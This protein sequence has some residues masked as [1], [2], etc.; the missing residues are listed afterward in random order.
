MVAGLING[1]FSLITF[2]NKVIREVGCGLYLLGSSMTTLITTIMFSLKFLILLLTQMTIISNRSFLLFQCHLTDFVLR[3]CLCMDQWLNACVA[4]ERA[5]TTT[6]GA[7]F[8]KKKS[9]K[10]SEV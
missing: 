7:R 5:I 9:K 1:L 10:S 6:K 8:D 2:K 3:V 4:M